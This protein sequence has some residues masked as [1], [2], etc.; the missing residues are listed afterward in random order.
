VGNC[1]QFGGRLVDLLPEPPHQGTDVGRLL[2]EF[3]RE[4]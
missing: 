2:R 4:P 1:P 3:A